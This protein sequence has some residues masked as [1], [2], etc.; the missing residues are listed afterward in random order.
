MTNGVDTAIIYSSTT[1]EYEWSTKQEFRILD[2]ISLSNNMRVY[3]QANDD[4]PG[5]VVEAMA[6]RL[7][8]RV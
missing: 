4:S 2:Y 6:F 3:F 5:N 1:P 7:N 8:N